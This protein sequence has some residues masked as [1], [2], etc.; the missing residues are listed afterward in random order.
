[1]PR[2]R[3]RR[4]LDDIGVPLRPCLA[5]PSAPEQR[6]VIPN[7]VPRRTVTYSELVIDAVRIVLVED[8]EIFRET[9]EMLLGLRA[10]LSV[11]AS[12]GSG[13]EAVDACARLQPDVVLVDYRM[14]GLNGAQTALAVL[15]AS[16]GSRVVCLTASVSQAEIDELLDAGAVDCVRKDEELE[17][18]VAAIHAAA[19]GARAA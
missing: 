9:L 1:M 5:P 13:S 17:R 11:V 10:D 18:I 8:N 16:P 19:V 2:P 14:P 3:K 6:S 4:Y 15:D 7:Q 12:V